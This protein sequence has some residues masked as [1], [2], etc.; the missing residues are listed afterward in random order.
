MI[1]F[2]ESTKVSY[3]DKAL[4]PDVALGAQHTLTQMRHDSEK[5]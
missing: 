4:K 5:S 3:F 1:R 2:I